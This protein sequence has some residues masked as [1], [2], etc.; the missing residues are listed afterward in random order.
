MNPTAFAEYD[1]PSRR[2]VVMARH[3]MV[4]TSQVLAAQAGLQVL[5]EGGNAVDAAVATAA[6]LAVVEPASTGPGGDAF[7]L[8]WQQEEGR[9]YGLN[10]SGGAPARL[11]ADLLR[12]Q[13]WDVV[14][15]D[16]PLSVT[17]PAG[18]QG[19]A[20]AVGRFG[21]LGLDRVLS[22]AIRYAE[23]GF[24]VTEQ[25]AAAWAAPGDKLRR[26][27]GPGCAYLP[28]GRGPLAGE[29]FRNPDLARTLRSIA[30]RGPEGF[31]LG[32]VAAHICRV[33]QEAGGVL[34]PAD[35]AACSVEWVEPL[36]VPY[37]GHLLY[38]L[39]PNGQG[40]VALLA[41]GMAQHFPLRQMGHNTAAYVHHLAEA[42]KEGF[43]EAVRHVAYPRFYRAPLPE[44]L[45]PAYL[46]ARAAAVDPFRASVL[47]EKLPGSGTVYLTVV[48]EERN[49]VSFINSIF[50][51]FGSGIVVPG[52]GV[53]LQNRGAC[54]TLEEGH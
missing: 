33:V 18:V 53:V 52:T 48:D 17:V 44:L 50:A 34:S 23:E 24:P 3:G 20:E 54:F 46:G 5:R 11:T 14:P 41:L 13:G 4:A 27:S 51:G 37:R 36:A 30:D 15:R 42:I 9:L 2:S 25:I 22:P 28:G 29:V 16:G 1:F 39:P 8:I 10:A 12:A 40:L 26:Y 47:R 6:V 38:E 21:R 19:W 32:E 35:M 45:S 7:A 43:R 31:Y 49:A